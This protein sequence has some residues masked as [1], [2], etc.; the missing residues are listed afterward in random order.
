MASR[1]SS[2]SLQRVPSFSLALRGKKQ[3][4]GGANKGVASLQVKRQWET[5]GPWLFDRARN[6]KTLSSRCVTQI[7]G[8]RSFIQGLFLPRCSRLSSQA[9][10]H[11][12]FFQQSSTFAISTAAPLKG[13]QH[14]P[15]VC[16]HA[17][18]LCKGKTMVHKISDC[19]LF[20]FMETKR[21]EGAGNGQ[22]RTIT[23]AIF[24]IKCQNMRIFCDKYKPPICIS[25][26]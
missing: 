11:K 3:H 5:N 24:T 13:R 23:F 14:T 2:S 26:G 6:S 16:H 20:V 25:Q 17:E 18:W 15:G 10:S 8:Y 22:Q 12:C 7:F 1:S 19:H 21:K 4:G 9:K